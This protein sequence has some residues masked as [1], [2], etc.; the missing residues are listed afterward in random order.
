M[1]EKKTFEEMV[2]AEVDFIGPDVD[3]VILRKTQNPP[4]AKNRR[5]I[6]E[7][8]PLVLFLEHTP[9]TPELVLQYEKKGWPVVTYQINT[10][11]A[12]A[13]KDDRAISMATALQTRALYARNAAPVQADSSIAD[14][15]AARQAA[16]KE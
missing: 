10:E 5:S 11:R 4:T 12:Q 14:K 2:A 8:V 9:V 6:S 16:K 3:Y 13:K 7:D 1:T 15:K